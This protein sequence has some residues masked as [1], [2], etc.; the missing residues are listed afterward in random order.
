MKL[1]MLCREPRLYS[2]QRLLEAATTCGHTL[3]IIDPNRCLL[4]LDQNQSGQFKIYYQARF[5][6]PPYLLPHYDAVIPRFGSASTSMGCALL[7]HFEALKIPCLNGSQAF[8]NAR[9]KWHSLMLLQQQNIAVPASA[10]CGNEFDAKYAVE[11]VRSPTILKTLSGSQGIG[12]MLAEKRQ[13]AVSILETLKQA[14]IAS[15]LQD[16]IGEANGSDIRCF[17][18]GD[19]IIASMQRSGQNGE[20]RANAHRGGQ[21][22]LIPLSAEEKAIALKAAQ[23]LGLEVAGVDIIRSNQGP[24]ILEVNASPGLELIEKTSKIDIALQMIIYLEKLIHTELI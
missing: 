3:D 7:R 20:F 22:Q 13:S 10:L 14:N 16:F 19:K 8:L 12:V 5:D 11:Q 23:I 9:D 17:V 18:V 21:A 6:Q 24:L 4:K 1:L 15:L 2:C